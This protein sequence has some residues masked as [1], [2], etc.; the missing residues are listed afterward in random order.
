MT[1]D[2]LLNRMMRR[3]MDAYLEMT[4]KYKIEIYNHV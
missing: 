1:R 2:D 4:D 3:D